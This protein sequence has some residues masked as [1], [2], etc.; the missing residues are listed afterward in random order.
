ME[1]G[2]QSGRETGP[3]RQRV[4]AALAVGVPA[5]GAL[6]FFARVWVAQRQTVDDGFIFFRFARNLAAG[7][8]LVWNL[9]WERAEGYTSHLQTLLLAALM[10]LGLD[11][12]PAGILLGVAGC[13]GT[14]AL[15]LRGLPRF[16][17]CPPWL[18]GWLVA[19]YL[20]DENAGLNATTGLETHLFTLSAAGLWYAAMRYV[21]EEVGPR[22][23]LALGAAAFL[24]PLAR[25]E[26]A[27]LAILTFAPLFFLQGTRRR[28]LRTAV[29]T[30]AVALAYLGW[31]Y[32]YFG[33]LLPNSFHVKVESAV[34]A[35]FGQFE[36]YA[37]E[38]CAP[39]AA[40]VVLF[41]PLLS[42]ARLTQRAA[43]HRG[44]AKW[45]LTLLPLAGILAFY[46]TSVDASSGAHRYYWPSL[47]LILAAAGALGGGLRTA[48]PVFVAVGSVLVTAWCVLGPGA[49]RLP[50][51][52]DPPVPLVSNL[53]LIGSA[54]AS[55]GLA[56][57]ATVV[58]DS[59][60]IV[61]YV[62]EFDLI[63]RSGLMDNYLSG[64]EDV[65]FRE[66]EDYV[67]GLEPD[68]YIGWEPPAT[69][70]VSEARLD[71]AATSAYVRRDLLRARDRG[72]E[73]VSRVFALEPEGL[74]RRMTEL[75]DHWHWLGQIEPRA[76]WE[77][78]WGVKL[79][80]YV[81][82]DSPHFE[83]LVEALQQVIE[84]PPE[85]VNL[86]Q[87]MTRVDLPQALRTER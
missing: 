48:P 40:V 63:D 22:P 76:Y 83:V 24:A 20:A 6:V 67:F 43:A 17:G 75:R 39:V 52:V 46:L 30:L 47:P 69:A 8:G 78:F 79:F 36:R 4:F 86:S 56:E 73:L 16:L 57:E 54:L 58:C 85:R 41:L 84:L 49:P 55:T 42:P 13:L 62:S 12:P 51:A 87:R 18:A 68:V 21:D 3:G 9:G 81:R 31:K 28:V 29:P 38:V 80:A 35:S 32:A 37:I 53:D 5:L 70:G 34:G 10:K 1:S 50:L 61:G 7:E 19:L 27:L 25:P 11:G 64:R 45:L 33:Y 71:P 82:R 26:G 65:S 14:A 59:A 2:A 72:G 23:G 77:P 15:L 44:V 66:R 74:Y 60:G